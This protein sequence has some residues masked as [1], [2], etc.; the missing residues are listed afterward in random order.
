MHAKQFLI[1]RNTRWREW[2]QPCGRGGRVHGKARY[3]DHRVDRSHNAPRCVI[4]SWRHKC[5]HGIEHQI[6]WTSAHSLNPHNWCVPPPRPFA[7][8][9]LSKRGESDASKIQK[10]A[11]SFGNCGTE[12][13]SLVPAR[14]WGARA[15]IV[16][17][18]RY[19]E[20]GDI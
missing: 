10:R 16:A 3:A 1:F 9:P 12:L 18:R 6:P 20:D 7:L 5:K 2:I 17:F 11:I 15:F 4:C 8:H 14:R 19:N 13:R